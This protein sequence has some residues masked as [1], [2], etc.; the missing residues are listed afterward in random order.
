MTAMFPDLLHECD[1]LLLST[2]RCL[3]GPVVDG[4]N[5]L[6]LNAV[7]G[8]VQNGVDNAVTDQLLICSAKP[9]CDLLHQR[10]KNELHEFFRRQPVA[11]Q[12]TVVD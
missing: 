11:F 8:G 1:G 5:D 9:P 12:E 7:A 6:G 10:R 2:S 3:E 4:L